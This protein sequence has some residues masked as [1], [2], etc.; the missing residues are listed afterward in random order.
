MENPIKMDDLGVPSR[1]LTITYPTTL[2]SSENHRLKMQFFDGDML[3]PRR[4]FVKAMNCWVPSHIFTNLQI[5]L[6]ISYIKHL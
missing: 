4:V 6:N 1:E 3:I 2:G 5:W